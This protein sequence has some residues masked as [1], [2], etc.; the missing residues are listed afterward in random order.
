MKILF[1]TV[2]GLTGPGTRARIM[3]YIPLLKDQQIET[4]LRPFFSAS[5]HRILHQPGKYLRKLC[6]FVWAICGR[7]SDLIRAAKADVV[8]ID[9]EAFPFGPPI[10]EWTVKKMGKRVVLDFDDALYAVFPYSTDTSSP[11][12]YRLKRSGRQFSDLVALSDQV[13]AGNRILQDWARTHNPNVTVI[14]TAIE[15]AYYQVKDYG[16]P[17]RGPVIIGWTGSHSTISYLSLI[18]NVIKQLANEFGD[19]VHFVI[20]GD[21]AFKAFVS[22]MTVREFVLETEIKDLQGFDIGIMPLND[23]EWSRGKCAWKALQYMAVGVPSISSP[24]GIVTDF[25]VQGENGFLAKTE[26][27]WFR[28]LTELV[29]DREKRM[30]V[31]L[32]GRK[33]IEEKFST[34]AW[35]PT[36]LRTVAHNR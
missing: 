28:V 6:M 14:P 8:Y 23:D 20:Q 36:F 3:S 33:T 31:G 19:R 25:I 12:L 30:K 13:I 29:H 22:Q 27:D 24:V 9:R 32:N 35:G 34:A 4:E 10:W 15:T 1:V 21:P 26:T 16:Q 7:L 11:L 17:S 5:F 18:Q 2:H